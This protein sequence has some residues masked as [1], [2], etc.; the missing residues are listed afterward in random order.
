MM[1]AGAVLKFKLQIVVGLALF[2]VYTFGVRWTFAVSCIARHN[3]VTF[4]ALN[5]HHYMILPYCVLKSLLL[6][7]VQH[8]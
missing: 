5:G 8:I 3:F 7:A 4:V 1:I 6:P 2:C